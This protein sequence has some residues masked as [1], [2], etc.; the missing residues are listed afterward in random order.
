MSN[1]C[2]TSFP[3]RH[4]VTVFSCEKWFRMFRIADLFIISSPSW[5]SSKMPLVGLNNLQS[6]KQSIYKLSIRHYFGMGRRR[7]VF[8]TDKLLEAPNCIYQFVVMHNML[9]QRTLLTT[10]LA[11]HTATHWH[12]SICCAIWC[13][14]NLLSHMIKTPIRM[15]WNP[16]NHITSEPHGPPP[17]IVSIISLEAISRRSQP[18]HTRQLVFVSSLTYGTCAFIAD[19]RS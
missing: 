17:F 13:H 14:S 2:I 3:D 4:K 8:G 15:D 16:T 19:S 18:Q 9:Y 10:G 6:I 12:T 1:S 7:L 5:F 11:I